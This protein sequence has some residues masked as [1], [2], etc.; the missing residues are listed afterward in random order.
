MMS[1]DPTT[2]QLLYGVPAAAKVLGISP[3]LCWVFVQRGELRTRRI[4]A[5]VLIHRRDLEKF[6]LRDH[7]TT[8]GEEQRQVGNV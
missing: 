3:R 5:R 6:A 7:S 8:N 1:A 4:G 2:G